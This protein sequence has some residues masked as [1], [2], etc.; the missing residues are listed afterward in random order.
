M[1]F[2]GVAHVEPSFLAYFCDRSR[3]KAADFR[4]NGFG[5]HAAHF[6]GASAPLFERRV[7]E[8]GK[9]IRIQYLV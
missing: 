6:D 1:Q 5:Q 3:I 7:V 9:R 8:V 4:E 2:V